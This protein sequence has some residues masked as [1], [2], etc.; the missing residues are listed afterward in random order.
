[1]TQDDGDY[2]KVGIDKVG[3]CSADDNS[4]EADDY[5]A[6]GDEDSI[7]DGV[8]TTA[9]MMI[10]MM[11]MIAVVVTMVTMTVVTIV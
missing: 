8:A 1:M 10:M 5:G 9:M 11:V 4:D 3:S 6:T 7:V 2:D